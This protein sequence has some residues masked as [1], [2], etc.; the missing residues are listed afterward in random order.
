MADDYFTGDDGK[1][2]ELRGEHGPELVTFNTGGR[3]TP[4]L[5][6]VKNTTDFPE[7]IYTER[8]LRDLLT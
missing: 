3:L 5:T 1:R 6:T 8:E 2:Y 7:R 4:G